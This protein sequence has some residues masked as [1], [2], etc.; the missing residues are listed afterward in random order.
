MTP[1]EIRLECLRLALSRQ[2]CE[3]IELAGRM[4]AFVTGKEAD[5]AKAKLG[6]VRAVLS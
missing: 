6:L 2:E 5:D 1:E 3:P 4:E